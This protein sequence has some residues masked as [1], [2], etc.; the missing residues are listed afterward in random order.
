MSQTLINSPRKRNKKVQT[1]E[2]TFTLKSSFFRNHYLLSLAREV[3]PNFM[4]KNVIF[5]IIKLA[6][7]L[8]WSLKNSL[9]H[10]KR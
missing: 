4:L 3:K 2:K 8:S 7:G 10:E 5:T 1:E 6:N 9:N